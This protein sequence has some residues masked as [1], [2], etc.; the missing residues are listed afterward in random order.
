MKKHLNVTTVLLAAFLAFPGA[1]F[2][3]E[4]GGSGGPA[5]RAQDRFSRESPEVMS[6]WIPALEKA[7]RATVR[8]T[9]KD[10]KVLVLGCAVHSDGWIVTKASEVIDRKGRLREGVEVRF[11]EGLRLPATLKDVHSRYDIALLKVEA[12]GLRVMD[13][14]HT[15]VP[16]PG[17]YLAA[18]SPEKLPVAVGVLSVP[19]RNLDERDKGFLGVSLAQE[20]SRVKVIRVGENTAAAIAGI[21][22]DDVLKSLNGKSVES[23]GEAISLITNFKP[24]D[25]VKVVV[26]RGDEEKELSATVWSRPEGFTGLTE[27]VRSLM[28]GNL[29]RSRRGFPAAMQHDMV[30]E[31]GECGGPL[32]D[33]DGN[34]V[35]LNIARSGRIDSYAVPSAV[36]HELLRTVTSGRFHRPELEELRTEL[37]NAEALLGRIR[38][39]RDRLV[40]QIAEA[41]G[42][43]PEEAAASPEGA[44][45]EAGREKE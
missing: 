13:F 1:A 23:V 27:D 32:V 21:R 43:L 33:L 45:Q 41:E 16:P 20:G 24:Y 42:A 12:R 44:K 14:S 34:V 19:P 2:A 30:L 3:E 25:T 9:T 29:S 28:S 17:S 18:A 39:D 10:D 37:R 11:P 31:P 4:S 6:A 38:S 26:Q 40:R 22:Q 35:G 15:E 8:I 7:R 5:G 36:V